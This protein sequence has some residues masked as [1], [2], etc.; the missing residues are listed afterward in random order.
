MHLIIQVFGGQICASY[1]NGKVPILTIKN[2]KT[3]ANTKQKSNLSVPILPTGIYKL[4]SGNV[5]NALRY[6]GR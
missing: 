4:A 3:K 5:L 6:L 1:S 2:I